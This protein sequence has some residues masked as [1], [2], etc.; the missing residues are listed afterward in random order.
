MRPELFGLRIGGH[1]L[2]VPSYG[3]AVMLGFALGVWLALRQARRLG[4]QLGGIDG[5]DL[6]D[7]SFYILV[8]GVAGSRLLFILLHLDDFS[9]LCTRGGDCLAPL[10][11]WDGG[12]V[13]YGGLIAAAA[14]TF[15]FVRRRGWRFGVVGD[16]FAPGL[17]LGHAVGRLGCFAAG[18]CFGKTCAAGGPPCVSFPAG[19]VAHEHLAA[20]GQ[21][22]P[23]ATRTPPLHPTQLYESAGLLLIFLLLLL[24]RRRQRFHGQLFLLYLLAYGLLRA[25]LDLFRGDG[26][27]GPSQAVGLALALIAGTWLLVAHRRSRGVQPSTRSEPRT[28]P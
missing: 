22:A 19:S 21:I 5:S 2:A 3:T 13:F 14:V 12:L 10:K 9:R 17:A 15:R 24:W 4:G 1:H 16:L 18:C 8:A 20:L 23:G 28:T 26:P 25:A 7:L 11:I 6:L 27:R